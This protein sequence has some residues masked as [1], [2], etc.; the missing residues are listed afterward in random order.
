MLLFDSLL[1][2]VL[3]GLA[4]GLT[5][6]VGDDRRA[7]LG[8]REYRLQQDYS[9]T[10][11]E[12][13]TRL[14]FERQLAQQSLGEIFAD[15]RAEANHE[16]TVQLEQLRSMVS[17][18]SQRI[19][20]HEQRAIENSP[21]FYSPEE[22]RRMVAAEVSGGRPVL[23]F[24]P[25]YDEDRPEAANGFGVALNNTWE[26]LAWHDSLARL[27]GLFRRPLQQSD[28]D[29]RVIR[30][31]LRG[32]PVVLI[33]GDVQAGQRVWT[34][35]RGWNLTPGIG[36]DH[37]IK[38]NLPRLSVPQP[39]AENGQRLEFQ[40]GL[41]RMCGTVAGVL[42]DWYHLFSTG[43]R[44]RVHLDCTDDEV[45]RS[46]G[47]ALAG[48]YEVAVTRGPTDRARARLA[49][50]RVLAE[51]GLA[52]AS[53][54]ATVNLSPQEMKGDKSLWKQVTEVSDILHRAGTDGTSSVADEIER[55]RTE[56]AADFWIQ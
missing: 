11:R 16:R 10:L 38:I 37:L 54:A 20:A 31:T 29:L 23:L 34:S 56:R 48:A 50:A 21:F 47:A 8:T 32:L 42:G 15:R 36:D 3:E 39:G 4:K 33:H 28:V 22:T 30:Q 2:K 6:M 35:L 17:I 9:A 14:Q 49:Q 12:K 13:E 25:F 19:V 46:V 5:T 24:A 1:V 51:S 41:A 52:A 40:D 44:P 55:V 53:V 18:E 26:Q 43:R 7:R 27:G 45:R